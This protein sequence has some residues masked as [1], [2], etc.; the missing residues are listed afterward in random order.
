MARR[1]ELANGTIVDGVDDVE[2]V[3]GYPGKYKIIMSTH[4]DLKPGEIIPLRHGKS[5]LPKGGAW[6]AGFD[7]VKEVF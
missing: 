7:M 4:E 1:F 3:Y 5:G 2:P 6:G